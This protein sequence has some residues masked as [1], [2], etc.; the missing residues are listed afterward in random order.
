M[1]E[2]IGIYPELG[3]IARSSASGRTKGNEEEQN[4]DSNEDLNSDQEV[5]EALRRTSRSSSIVAP[6]IPD[7]TADDDITGDIFGGPSHDDDLPAEDDSS[8]VDAFPLVES[9]TVWEDGSMSFL[10]LQTDVLCLY[11][12]RIRLRP[13]LCQRIEAGAIMPKLC[14]HRQ[15]VTR[16]IFCRKIQNVPE[17]PRHVNDAPQTNHPGPAAEEGEEE[18][19]I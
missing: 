4:S 10:P 11:H 3:R 14:R 15:E 17:L 18:G 7:S 13:W 6:S 5:V 8:A 9:N 12:R 19:V 1:S 16:Q 2:V